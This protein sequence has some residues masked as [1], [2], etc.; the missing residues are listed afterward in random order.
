MS[1]VGKELMCFQNQH[2]ELIKVGIDASNPKIMY[3]YLS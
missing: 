1:L 3:L 2:S